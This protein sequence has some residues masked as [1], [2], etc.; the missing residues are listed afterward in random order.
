[1]IKGIM[2]DARQYDIEAFEKA[3]AGSDITIKYYDTH[4]DRSTAILA[5][6]YDCVIAFVNDS[7][8]KETIDILE[9]NGVRLIALRCAGFNNVDVRA[10]Y[11]RIHIVRVPSYSP[12]AVAEHAA[13]LLLTLVRRI[14]KAYIRTK[15]FNFSLNGLK[16]FNLFGKTVGVVGTGKI[17][18]CFI[19][20]MKGFGLRVLAY[21][22]FP[23]DRSDIEYVSLDELF[24]LSDVISLHCPLTPDTKHIINAD[25]INKMK[26]GVVLI[27]TSRG[28]LIDTED[29]LDA[30]KKEKVGGACLDVYEE[31][32][33]LF[34]E[35]YSDH[36][37]Q[38]D[39]IARLLTMPNVIIT[40]HQAFLTDEALE[41]IA[42]T[43]KNNIERFFSDGKIEN[44]VCYKC[45][46]E[47]NCEKKRNEKCF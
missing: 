33:D 43:T 9:K 8:D 37:V 22:P 13:A 23:S 45:G 27:N 32:S 42:E 46:N 44:E 16:G 21:D 15:D 36:I 14:H 1:M 39:V 5:G 24:A 18:A 2:F 40:S 10:A 4:L 11:G 20:I 17:G 7:I 25:S 38:D 3:I 12:H 31:E 35:D 47:K 29:L 6:G 34:F 30:I 26:K 28:G 19:D 41:N